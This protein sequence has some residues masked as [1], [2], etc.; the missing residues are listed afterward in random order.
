MVKISAS[1]STGR[2]LSEV[3]V[4][5]R[6]YIETDTW[7]DEEGNTHTESYRVY[8]RSAIICTIQIFY[9]FI[10]VSEIYRTVYFLQI[11]SLAKVGDTFD[12]LTPI[13]IYF[14]ISLLSITMLLLLS[15]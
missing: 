14:S 15:F 10:Y 2:S 6:Y 3:E 1:M 13:H 5:R 11:T 4:E 8:A 12:D 7:T 9:Y